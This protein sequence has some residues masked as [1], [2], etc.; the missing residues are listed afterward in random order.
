VRILLDLDEVLCDFVGAACG[1]WGV[2]KE[3]VL[4]HWEKGVWDLIPPLSRALGRE[5]PL[6]EAE[7]WDRINGSEMF[8][9]KL[10]PT[11]WARGVLALTQEITED[12]HVISA[13][14]SCV[15]SYCGKV[16]WLKRFFGIRFDRFAITPHK[17]IF[18]GESVILIDDRDTNIERFCAA[19]GQGIVFPR[20]HNSEH[21]YQDNPLARLSEVLE[22]TA[23]VYKKE[24]PSWS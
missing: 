13:P 18:A 19:G 12:W 2:R 17:E 15:S 8:W 23:C 20:H 3:E 6:L 10:E 5:R 14:S 4:R 1:A 21:P 22:K 16:R 11:P 7:F 24:V 9:A